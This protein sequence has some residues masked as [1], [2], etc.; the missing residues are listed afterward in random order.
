MGP[1]HLSLDKSVCN[2]AIEEFGNLC[3]SNCNNYTHTFQHNWTGETVA[4]RY[5]LICKDSVGTHP[6]IHD[7][8]TIG[9]GGL[10]VGA[11]VF[12]TL[13]DL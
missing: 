3:D 1:H 13:S 2:E 6:R 7:A 4:S 5:N 10:L 12:G 8:N 9:L 11:L